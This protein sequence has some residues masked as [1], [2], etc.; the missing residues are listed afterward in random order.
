[1]VDSSVVT[2]P[3]GYVRFWY[4]ISK[5]FTS[6]NTCTLYS[7]AFPFQPSIFKYEQIYEIFISVKQSE[8][9]Y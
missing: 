9:K 5:C 4:A 6:F 8:F 2:P 1:M 3:Q 7:R